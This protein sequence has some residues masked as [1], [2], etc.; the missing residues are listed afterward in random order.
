MSIA[1]WEG[2]MVYCSFCAE[3]EI[4]C[5]D[6]FMCTLCVSFEDTIFL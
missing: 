2:E 1:C 6:T 4:P 5:K 3:P